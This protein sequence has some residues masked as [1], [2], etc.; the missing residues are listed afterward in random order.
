[1]ISVVKTFNLKKPVCVS[2]RSPSF[3][4]SAKPATADPNTTGHLWERGH[5]ASTQ[6]GLVCTRRCS[7]SGFG[8]TFDPILR[9]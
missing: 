8:H 7:T 1:M 9:G 2:L 3:A 4:V 5:Y 6:P